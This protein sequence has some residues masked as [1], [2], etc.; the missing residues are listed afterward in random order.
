MRDRPNKYLSLDLDQCNRPGSRCEPV[1]AS[2]SLSLSLSPFS[3]SRKRR[4]DSHSR[5][6]STF[7]KIRRGNK[8]K[9]SYDVR[10]TFIR[11]DKARSREP[12]PL[13]AR[14]RQ[15]LCIV[16]C[17]SSVRAET[18][19][20]IVTGILLLPPCSKHNANDA[21]PLSQRAV[22]LSSSGSGART[23]F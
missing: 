17:T 5:L 13:R 4:E 22:T 3:F 11:S 6:T 9:S 10:L 7:F 14:R 1:T 21:R 2:F 15:L 23:H 19:G 12:R 20:E 18:T 8:V 16:E